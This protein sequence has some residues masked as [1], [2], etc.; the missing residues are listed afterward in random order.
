MNKIEFDRSRVCA[1]QFRKVREENRIL[2]NQYSATDAEDREAFDLVRKH[3]MGVEMPLS[4]KAVRVVLPNIEVREVVE[5]DPVEDF[6]A[7][8][9]NESMLFALAC[10]AI[11]LLVPVINWLG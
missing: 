4:D 9:S 11:A 8:V 1:A 7:S 3:R 2:K 6:I 5:A 10:A